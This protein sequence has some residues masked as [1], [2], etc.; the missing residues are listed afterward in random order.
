MN[1]LVVAVLAIIAWQLVVTI[2][3]FITDEDET[4]V[5][6]TA[7]GFCLLRLLTLFINVFL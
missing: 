2:M 1:Y 5:M 6:R 4:I 3:C 7:I